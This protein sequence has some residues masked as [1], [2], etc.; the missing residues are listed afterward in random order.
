MSSHGVR[1]G[2]GRHPLS[3]IHSIGHMNLPTIMIMQ[4]PIVRACLTVS[5]PVLVIE[6]LTYRGRKTQPVIDTELL[7]PPSD[8]EAN[9][10]CCRGENE[11]QNA[12]N[13]NAL[14][15]DV[16]HPEQKNLFGDG[17]SRGL[18]C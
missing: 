14:L 4:W 8:D 2:P 9:R 10:Y 18:E 6:S 7:P 12:N 5:F 16:D 13:E 15:I 11:E 3:L 17:S 1:S